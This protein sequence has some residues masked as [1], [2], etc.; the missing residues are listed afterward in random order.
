VA[1]LA[2]DAYAYAYVRQGD[3]GAETVVADDL[4]SVTIGS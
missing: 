2:S 1:E 3:Y 4:T